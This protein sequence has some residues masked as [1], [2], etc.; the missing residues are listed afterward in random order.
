[1]KTTCSITL[2]SILAAIVVA[3]EA[4]VV[5]AQTPAKVDFVRDV[6]PLF[7]AHCT[8]CHGPKQ[9]K[10]GFRLDRRRDAFRGG[11]ANCS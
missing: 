6:Q 5:S 11:V 8:G 9:Q 4:E 3:C 2:A 7:K 10:N 1:M